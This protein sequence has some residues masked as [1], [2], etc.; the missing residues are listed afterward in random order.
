ML[1]SLVG[2]HPKVR[3]EERRLSF[4]PSFLVAFARRIFRAEQVGGQIRPEKWTNDFLGARPDEDSPV[5]SVVC[6]LVLAV[7][8]PITTG[9]IDPT[10]RVAHVQ[11]QRSQQARLGRPTASDLLKADHALYRPRHVRE[12]SRDVSGIDRLHSGCLPGPDLTRRS[13]GTACKFW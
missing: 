4:G 9:P 11:I 2:L 1:L 6:G 13:P 8:A 3:R 5:V 10:V 12:S 7:G